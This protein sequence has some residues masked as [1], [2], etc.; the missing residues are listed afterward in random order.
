MTRSRCLL[1]C[2]G[3]L[4][5]LFSSLDVV[6]Q[7]SEDEEVRNPLMRGSL[8]EDRAASQPPQEHW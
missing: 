5:G 7:D 1:L 3:L 6:A 8:I 4:I 2:T